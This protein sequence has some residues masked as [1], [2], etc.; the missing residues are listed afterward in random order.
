MLGIW[1]LSFV[2]CVNPCGGLHK[3]LGDACVSARM[4]L[5]EFRQGREHEEPAEVGAGHGSVMPMV[6]FLSSP[7]LGGQKVVP[8]CQLAIKKDKY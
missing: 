4:F 5:G 3:K 2:P 7:T 1:G 8:N 6:V